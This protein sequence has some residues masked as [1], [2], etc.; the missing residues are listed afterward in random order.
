MSRFHE[1]CE[2]CAEFRSPS[3]LATASAEGRC[4]LLQ[5]LDVMWQKREIRYGSGFCVSGYSLKTHGPTGPEM[6][7]GIKVRVRALTASWSSGT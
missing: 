5:T 7:R 4:T 6:H 2:A 1:V 3:L